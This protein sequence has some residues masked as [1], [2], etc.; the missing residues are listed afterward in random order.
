MLRFLSS[1]SAILFYAL[2]GSFFLAYVL[3]HNNIGSPWPRLWL[4]YADLPLIAAALLYGCISLYRSVRHD[5]HPSR[6]IALTVGLPA[7]ILF[8]VILWVYFRP[9]FI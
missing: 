3:L 8:A 2:A 6:T 5:A 1:V 4:E 7:S 9:L